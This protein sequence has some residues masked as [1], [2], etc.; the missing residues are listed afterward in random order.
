MET[1]PDDYSMRGRR[2]HSRLEAWVVAGSGAVIAVCWVPLVFITAQP[3][4]ATPLVRCAPH[5]PH[6]VFLIGVSPA[7]ERALE[8]GVRFGYVVML[9]GVGLL[10]LGRLL[11][12]TVPMRRML[13]PVLVASISGWIVIITHDGAQHHLVAALLRL[14]LAADAIDAGWPSTGSNRPSLLQR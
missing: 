12:S 1:E 2:L 9:V 11:A 8:V 7:L 4:I 6:N 14:D 13:L 5:C 10:L 3:V